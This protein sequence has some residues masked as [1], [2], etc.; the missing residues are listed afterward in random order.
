MPDSQNAITARSPARD[1]RTRVLRIFAYVLAGCALVLAGLSASA[2]ERSESELKAA[3]LYHF[4]SYV[5]WPANAFE[6]ADAPFV[7]G[8]VGADD[9]QG[10]LAAI[11][12]GRTVLD[13]RISVRRLEAGDD[14]GAAH[15]LFIG[16]SVRPGTADDLLQRARGLPVLTVTEAVYV[17]DAGIRFVIDED[18]VRFD[19]SLPVVQ[20]A[21]LR[22]SSRL[23]GIARRVEGAP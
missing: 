12:R 1:A 4:G 23:L 11:V 6:D 7:I 21:D 16:G 18:R 10:P 19:I 8:L 2:Q 5:D 17:R 15:I 22:I 3:F 13:R 20:E 9:I 14:P